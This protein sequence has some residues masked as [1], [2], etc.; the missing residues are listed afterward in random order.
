[1]KELMTALSVA[2][3]AIRS[4]GKD[5][6]NDFAKY[7]YVSA[8][9]MISECRRAL[10]KAG[11]V[12]SRTAWEMKTTEFG[13]T[14]VSNYVLN[15]PESGEQISMSSE[16]IVP[17]AQKQL[18]KATL[19]ALTTSLNYMLRDML[20]IPRADEPEVDNM[21]E[22]ASAPKRAAKKKP[23]PKADKAAESGSTVLQAALALVIGG[24]ANPNDYEEALFRH[25]SDQYGREFR[26]VD[27]LPDDYVKRVVEAHDVK[28]EAA[29]ADDRALYGDKD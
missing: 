15:H 22:P 14:V 3:K 19:A 29:D 12:F 21:P 10:H 16:M 27:Q 1:V 6:K 17:P 2:Q 20:L 8:E 28:I 13:V 9:T 18:D 11:L 23:A 26:S 5:A 24:K 4:V 25:A 7:D